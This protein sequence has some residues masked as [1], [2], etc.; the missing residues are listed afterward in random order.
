MV[1]PLVQWTPARCAGATQRGARA[2]AHED[3]LGNSV[4]CFSSVGWYLI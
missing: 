4:W 1:M 2:E 3:R